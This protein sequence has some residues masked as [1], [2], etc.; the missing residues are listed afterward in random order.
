MGAQGKSSHSP[1][2]ERVCQLGLYRNSQAGPWLTA[3]LAE[4]GGP[5]LLLLPSFFFLRQKMERQLQRVLM[6]PCLAIGAASLTVN[7]PHQN[8][9]FVNSQ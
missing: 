8:G 3:L 4:G 5:L 2:Q 7:N 1:W 6:Y 9:T